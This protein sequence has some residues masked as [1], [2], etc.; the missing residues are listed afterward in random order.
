M[1]TLPPLSPE[2]WNEHF[3]RYKQSPEFKLINTSMTLEQFKVIFW[4]EWIHR[5]IGRITGLVF[6][7]G[8]LFFTLTK[9]FTRG[10]FFRALI[11]LC[12]GAAQGLIGWWMVKSGLVDD[13][14]VDH[15]RLA[16]HLIAAF[17]AFGFSFWFA[18]QL[19]F[20]RAEELNPQTP[21]SRCFY[22]S[23]IVLIGLVVQI[24]YGA[25]VAG[26]KAGYYYPTW[27]K[28]GDAWFPSNAILTSGSLLFD[29]TENPVGVQFVHRT[30]AWVV[31]VM[32]LTLWAY[33]KRQKLGRRVERGIELLVVLTIVQ[34]VLGIFTLL[35]S[36]PI[37]LAAL[38]QS[39]A[40]FLFA[41]MLYVIF[42]LAGAELRYAGEQENSS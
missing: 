40:F 26:L 32:V 25:F 14:H 22:L 3:S 4:W 15:F 35:L 1:G 17:T 34:I 23:I 21:R 36:V 39:V 16:I 20:E 33:T 13:P 12:I 31:V 38:H 2:S 41:N 29:L 10:L 8:F 6:F 37:V 11:L 28:M 5:L 30:L 24:V 9:K 27:P 7:T 18:L 42:C 19:M